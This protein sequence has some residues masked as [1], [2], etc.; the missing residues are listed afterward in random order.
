MSNI[1]FSDGYSKP[2]LQGETITNKKSRREGNSIVETIYTNKRTIS[3]KYYSPVTPPTPPQPKTEPSQPPTPPPKKFEPKET[4]RIYLKDKGR[5]ATDSEMKAR[6]YSKD[7]N[8][9]TKVTAWTKKIVTP[10]PS[11]P[12]PPKLTQAQII[13]ELGKVKERT[14]GFTPSYVPA[15]KE[16]WEERITKK[17]RELPKRVEEYEKNIEAL[18][19]ESHKA[20]SRIDSRVRKYESEY[21]KVSAFGGTLDSTTVNLYSKREVESY[22]KKIREYN[23]RIKEL[24]RERQQLESFQKTSLF[25]LEKKRKELTTKERTLREDIRKYGVEAKMFG[26]SELISAPEGTVFGEVPLAKI[27]VYKPPSEKELITRKE[28]TKKQ[29]EVDVPKE[30]RGA[31]GEYLALGGVIAGA[32]AVYTAG[33]SLPTAPVTILGTAALG[34][35]ARIGGKFAESGYLQAV[36]PSEAEFVY[37][38]E[39]FRGFEPISLK[40]KELSGQTE[41]GTPF[42]PFTGKWKETP[43]PKLTEEQKAGMLGLGV[44]IGIIA[45]PALTYVAGRGIGTKLAKGVPKYKLKPSKTVIGVEPFAEPSFPKLY[46]TGLLEEA[47]TYKFLGKEFSKTKKFIYTFKGKGMDYPSLKAE[48]TIE[49]IEKQLLREIEPI[50]QQ[51]LIAGTQARVSIAKQELIPETGKFIGTTKVTPES[52]WYKIV[53]KEG[54]YRVVPRFKWDVP[55]LRPRALKLGTGGTEVGKVVS[56][57]K[58]VVSYETPKEQYLEL[59]GQKGAF[60]FRAG[61]E[62][63]LGGIGKA[64]FE[65]SLKQRIIPRPK[66]VR[67]K[68]EVELGFK[69]KVFPEEEIFARKPKPSSTLELLKGKVKVK[70]FRATDKEFMKGFKAPKLSKKEAAKGLRQY[71]LSI[72]KQEF[73]KELEAGLKGIQS[74]FAT[75]QK[76]VKKIPKT[77]VVTKPVQPISASFIGRGRRMKPLAFEVYEEVSYAP[78]KVSVKE[79]MK[80]FQPAKAGLVGLTS[81]KEEVVPRL[82]PAGLMERMA[83][84]QKTRLR[85]RAARIQKTGLGEK[86]MLAQKTGLMEGIKTIQAPRIK[87]RALPKLKAKQIGITMPKVRVPSPIPVLKVPV[88]GLPIWLGGVKEKAVVDAGQGF[89]VFAKRHATKKGKRLVKLNKRILTRQSALGLGARAV[90][91]TVSQEFRI[92]KA[93]GKPKSI[94]EYSWGLLSHKFRPRIK[95]KKYVRDPN[96][97]IEK[98]KHAIDTFGELQGITVK[99]WKA[100]RRKKLLTSIF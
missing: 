68:G 88:L 100:R 32:E 64:E 52:F 54:K 89:N 75:T 7:Y 55:E 84:I 2:K 35:V 69:A 21:E 66:G 59:L 99:G 10:P 30:A 56:P 25:S 49:P 13:R 61:T 40:W 16:S 60:A 45:A 65:R 19:I 34:T 85:E 98:R 86:T 71:Q 46:S 82:K 58:Q 83:A 6:G 80:L 62:K 74:G 77:K 3:H 92:K 93:K 96:L 50:P 44:E 51:P 47:R 72:M 57:A 79:A 76:V 53:E 63:E 37:G 95:K 41:M 90:D 26:L 48:K 23:K 1:T 36:R 42:Y 15:G 94:D 33:V 14:T 4:G 31:M 17:E 29:F 9:T 11:P 73:E 20:R 43:L 8:V 38:K 39:R 18:E 78:P 12:K 28:L 24:E 87:E 27:E 97:F 91:Q 22:N 5:H 70:G 81:L 67:L